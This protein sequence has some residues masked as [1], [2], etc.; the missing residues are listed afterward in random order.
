M[1]QKMKGGNILKILQ[2]N[3]VITTG[4]T[5]S[6]AQSIGEII[7]QNGDEVIY[8]CA[9]A[10]NDKAYVI[11]T[12]L[13]HKLHAMMSRVFGVQGYFSIIA[14]CRLIKWINKEKP[15]IIHLH[16]LHSNFIN[17]I[18][19]MR[20]IIKEK[21]PTVI[22]LHDCWYFTG[23]CFHYLYNDCMRWKDQCGSC[24][25]KHEEQD[26]FFFDR[27]KRVL[28]DKQKYIGNNENVCVVGCS[29]WVTSEAK[30]SIL[31]DR[32]YGTICNGIN[33]EVFKPKNESI[34]KKYKLDGKF[35]ILG[36]AN[37]WLAKENA[38]TFSYITSKLNPNMVVMLVGAQPVLERIQSEHIILV[39]RISD[40]NELAEYYSAADVFV[41]ITKADTFPTVNM[42]AIACGTPVI[43]YDSGG[44][45]EIV[46]PDVGYVVDFGNYEEMMACICEIQ[47]KGKGVLTNNC[48][49]RAEEKYNMRNCFA[50][51]VELYHTII[52]K[53]GKKE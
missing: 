48:R 20:Y 21:I 46:T 15:D 6:I 45:S 26:S 47:R 40:P 50:Q 27:S 28:K 33:L 10:P 43:T 35:L 23:K 32:I 36:M 25:R 19:L 37:K 3:A 17:Y 29:E 38:E 7:E 5:G 16:N 52:S 4:S 9:E 18:L 44:S 14:T 8:A 53:K 34:R 49:K 2:I 22:T 11:G 31:K 12:R 1:L 24:P 39:P 30:K 13:D 51:Y 42:E 41:N